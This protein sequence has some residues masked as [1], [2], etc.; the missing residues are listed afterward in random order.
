MVRQ[1]LHE[2]ISIIEKSF[3]KDRNRF[4]PLFRW[5]NIKQYSA[6]I[7]LLMNGQRGNVIVVL[8]THTCP[9]LLK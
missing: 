8:G 3:E 9:K 7:N 6:L 1:K 5:C 4:T 2:S